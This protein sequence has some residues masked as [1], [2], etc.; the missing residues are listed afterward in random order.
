[1]PL[2]ERELR[3]VSLSHY[4]TIGRSMDCS[5]RKSES[6]HVNDDIKRLCR[7]RSGNDEAREVGSNQSD[8]SNPETHRQYDGS[9]SVIIK[10][11]RAPCPELPPSFVRMGCELSHDHKPRNKVDQPTYLSRW[12]G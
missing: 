2:G 6:V 7:G 5:R 10:T 4:K 1:M 8:S 11:Y 12:Y 3:S 9:D